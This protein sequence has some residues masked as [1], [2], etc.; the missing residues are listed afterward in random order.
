MPD[1]TQYDYLQNTILDCQEFALEEFEIP[2]NCWQTAPSV[3]I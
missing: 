2:L 1:G 3:I